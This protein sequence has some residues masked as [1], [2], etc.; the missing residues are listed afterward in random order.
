MNKKKKLL[1][2]NWLNSGGGEPDYGLLTELFQQPDNRSTNIKLKVASTYVPAFYGN[3]ASGQNYGIGEIRAYPTN[4][5]VV[6]K[7]VN[8]VSGSPDN[9]EPPSFSNPNWE[10]DVALDMIQDS[11]D[12]VHFFR[13]TLQ[14]GSDGF[15]RQNTYQYGTYADAQFRHQSVN[16]EDFAQI[17]TTASSMATNTAIP[18]SKSF[19][20]QTG[21][22]QLYDSVL[23]NAAFSSTFNVPTTHPNITSY[24][25]GT[26]LSIAEGDTLTFY[27]NSTNFFVFV[28]Y[29]Y[30]SVTG[31]VYGFSTMHVGSG[32]FSSWEVRKEVLLYFKWTGG[33]VQFHAVLKTYDS[34]TGASTANMIFTSASAGALTNWNITYAKRPP[35]VTTSQSTNFNT[36]GQN[37]AVWYFGEFEGT[38]L[39]HRSIKQPSGQGFEYIYLD[40]P[41]ILN[42][43]SNVTVDT[44][45]AGS[46][47][48]Q[49][50]QAFNN[51]TYADS[52]NK[53][54]FVAVS[55]ASPN[56]A[57]TNATPWIYASTNTGLSQ[58]FYGQVN[59][60][61]FT[62]D[63]DFGITD[64]QSGGEMAWRFKLDGSAHTTNWFP[65]HGVMTNRRVSK[66]FTVDGVL[67]DVA[68]I[69]SAVNP[70]YYKY[71]DFTTANLLQLGALIHPEDAGDFADYT[72]VHTLDKSG[73]D[74]DIQF[75][76]LKATY[77]E[78]GYNNQVS[79]SETGYNKIKSEDGV[80]MLRPANNTVVNMAADFKNQQS[81]L[82][83]NTTLSSPGKDLVLGAYWPDITN[84]RAGLAN[85]GTSFWQDFSGTS[86]SKFYPFAYSGYVTTIGEMVRIRNKQ[87]FGKWIDANTNL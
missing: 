86:G 18:S 52:S 59:Y 82:Y 61:L 79:G 67:I 66:A 35:T 42:P 16:Y 29:K 49:S 12:G 70:Y 77:I 53:H 25:I 73:L 1:L 34:G 78:S 11:G 22:P 8:V 54:R 56:G 9:L 63:Y 57:S 10:L 60:D 46:L 47:T 30:D 20:T 76:W 62:S 69:S 37:I 23:L 72:S 26:G 48:N 81:Y 21:L 7:T 64:A 3:W 5:Q 15:V 80:Y 45:D 27:G 4:S 40:G 58:S 87:Y 31:I 74:W 44:Y 13:S 43:P 50:I 84:W 71:Q 65:W 68:T 39:M 19:T 14:G 2:Y 17:G 51:L 33:A 32:S 24:T 38:S 85:S 28:V 55:K 75:E 36:G 6:W 83:Y 41:D